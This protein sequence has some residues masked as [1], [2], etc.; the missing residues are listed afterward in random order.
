MSITS[1]SFEN[2]TTGTEQPVENQQNERIEVIKTLAKN[3]C[4]NCGKPASKSCNQCKLVNY[5]DANCQK[6]AWTIHKKICVPTSQI[7]RYTTLD[8]QGL[9]PL[10]YAVLRG[11]ESTLLPAQQA[12]LSLVKDSFNGTPADLKNHLA[13]ASNDLISLKM[14]TSDGKVTPLTQDKFLELTGVRFKDG[15]MASPEVLLDLHSNSGKYKSINQSIDHIENTD[16]KVLLFDS[17][18]PIVYLAEEQPGMG[19]GVQAGQDIKKGELICCTGGELVITRRNTY[20]S[21]MY[22]V[23][24]FI[25]QDSF[26]GPAVFIY[27]GPPNCGFNCI[28]N[29]KGIPEYS[30]VVALRDIKKGEFLHLNYGPD[31]GLRGGEYTIT[32]QADKEIE[33]FCQNSFYKEQENIYETNC[34]LYIWG[35]SS[36]FIQL[37]L[38]ETLD[39]KKTKDLMRNLVMKHPPTYYQFY[40]SI[41]TFIDKIHGLKKKDEKI[42]SLIE[43]L[44]KSLSEA[45]FVQMLLEMM[46]DTPSSASIPAYQTLGS[47]Y[48]HLYLVV[49]GTLNGSYVNRDEPAPKKELKIPFIK[50]KYDSLPFKLKHTFKEQVLRYMIFLKKNQLFDKYQSF[51][52]L[53]KKL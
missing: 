9:T 29:Y 45:A 39:V 37:H 3:I 31:H 1:L 47:L 24:K 5:C 10:H 17:N 38:R 6:T 50:E 7:E 23:Q 51:D 30:V 25:S 18:P 46:E 52:E 28:K 21:A 16:T 32:P 33:N 44:S 13:P 53:K 14:I 48:D 4:D 19:L 2:K 15:Y 11:K 12:Q 40:D 27:D 43:G 20:R 42:I 36:L 35:V 8:N 26:S 49:N 41:L 22:N 34:F